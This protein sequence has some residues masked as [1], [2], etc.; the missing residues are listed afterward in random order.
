MSYPD[1]LLEMSSDDLELREMVATLV[2]A[3]G[4]L[5]DAKAICKALFYPS[6]FALQEAKRRGK[7][8]FAALTLE[9]RP[10]MF[11]KTEEIAAIVHR[12]R[13]Q[14][15]APSHPWIKAKNLHP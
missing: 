8:P 3:H 6:N 9:G 1:H 13:A 11:A 15:P 2:Q 5:M 10:G 14:S 12:A 7:L 4:P